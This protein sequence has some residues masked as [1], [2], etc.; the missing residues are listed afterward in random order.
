MT[1]YDL[2]AE[3]ARGGMGRVVDAR[4]NLLGRRVAVKQATAT[5]PDS[6]QRF[7]REV[8]ITARLEHPAIVP[9]HDAGTLD[10]GEP[11]YVMR[12]IAGEGLD[13]LIHARA[14]L[15]RRLPLVPN[16]AIAANAI[17]HAHDRGV[18]HRDL[19]A[20]SNILVGT[21]TARPS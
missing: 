13:A 14:E 4:D 19:E 16:L 10:T 17:A 5:D 2:G 6:L 3:I 9:V 12:K 11:Y 18:L 8:Q 21:L 1:R 20:V 15:D 7:A